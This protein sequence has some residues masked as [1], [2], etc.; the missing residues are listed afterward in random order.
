MT[1]SG[2]TSIYLNKEAKAAMADDPRTPSEIFRD[3]LT[4]RNG[5]LPEPVALP[6][7]PAKGET[8]SIVMPDGTTSRHVVAEV[9]PEEGNPHA[10]TMTLAEE[11]PTPAPERTVGQLMDLAGAGDVEFA[12][13]PTVRE[14]EPQLGHRTIK[15]GSGEK[16]SPPAPPLPTGSDFLRAEAEGR[17]P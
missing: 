4:V 16:A 9:V 2:K 8:V 11:T 3:G 14:A 12:P 15:L 7:A 13:Y 10:W 17:R 1:A 5:Q 6:T